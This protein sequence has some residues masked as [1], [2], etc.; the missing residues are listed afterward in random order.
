LPKKKHRSPRRNGR[1]LRVRLREVEP[2]SRGSNKLNK[3]DNN[4]LSRGGSIQNR[5]ADML[6]PTLF[7][8]PEVEEEAEEELSHVLHVGRMDIKPWIVQTGRWTEEKLTS[9]RHRGMML[10]M[11]TPKVGSH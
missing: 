3:E 11:N 7:L 9:Q 1:D 8:V 6:T 2:H 4:M 5:M 10:R